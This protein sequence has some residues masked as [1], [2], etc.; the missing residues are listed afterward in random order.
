MRDKS[1]KD[2][3]GINDLWSNKYYIF[4]VCL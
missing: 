1:F 4:S 3:D 2:Q